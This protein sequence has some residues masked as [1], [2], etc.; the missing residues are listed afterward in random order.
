MNKTCIF[1]GDF[2]VDLTRYGNNIHA[3]TFYDDVSSF[4]FRPLILQP[5][6]VTSNSLTLIDNI[7]INDIACTSNGGNITSSISDH[8]SQFCFLDIFQNVRSSSKVKYSRDW[9]NFNK[10]RFAYELSKYDWINVTSPDLGTN[11]STNNFFDNVNTLLDEMAPIKMLTKKEKGLM[12]RPW[13]TTG[14]LASMKSRDL[15]YSNFTREKDPSAKTI[16]FDIYKTKRNRVT[17]LIRAS[18]KDYYTKYFA[19]NNTNLK[20][21]WTGIRELIN[22]NKKSETKI[23]KLIVENNVITDPVAM[24]STMNSFFVNMGSSVASKIPN[25]KKGFSAYLS[26][27]SN[28]NIILNP[29]STAEINKLI[30]DLNWS[31]ASGPYSIP[32]NI[33]RLFKDVFVEPITSLVNKSLAEGIFPDILKWASVLPFFKKNDKTKCSNYRPISLLSNISKIF[34]RAMYNK[35]K[36]FLNEFNII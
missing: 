33:I 19:E 2:N 24:A 7:F 12:E 35:I 5:T 22:V 34:E 13:I 17:L 6:R 15:A 16:K 20:K 30:S 31:K 26:E 10:Q 25:S 27:S 21:T 8:F 14:I 28:F 32:S 3:D 11:V 18:K 23:S 9:R 36:L 4:S 1:A 29:C